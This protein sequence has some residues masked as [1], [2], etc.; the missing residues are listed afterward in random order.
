MKTLFKI[1]CGVCLVALACSMRAQ[2][3]FHKG[4]N[5]D[6]WLQDKNVGLTQFTRCTK[7]DFINIK[8][9]GCDVIR[10]PI[11]LHFMTNGA[12]DYTIDP[13]LFEYLDSA[14]VWAEGLKIYL[15][16]DNHTLTYANTDPGVGTIL[17]KIWP[18]MANRYKGHSSY[19]FYEVLNE[20]YGITTKVWGQIQQKAIDA[21]RAIDTTHTIIIGG[22]AWNSYNE[23]QNLPVYSDTNLIYTFHFYDPF[24]FTTQGEDAAG[25]ESLAGVPFPYDKNRMPASPASLKGTWAEILLNDYYKTETVDS[26]K[27][28]LDVAIA[29]KRARKV[30]VYCGEF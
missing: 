21:I 11:N 10:L 6:S 26:I 15:I 18:Q 20:P 1:F 14:V 2:V 4:V 16:L 9:L 28:L 19:I 5:L 13:L 25:L 27:K 7:Q 8:S 17:T 30:P 29:F 22:S 24:I 12:P 3:P 23:L